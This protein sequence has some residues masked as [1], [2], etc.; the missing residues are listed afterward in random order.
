MKIDDIEC[1]P[2]EVAIYAAAQGVHAGPFGNHPDNAKRSRFYQDESGRVG[3][4]TKARWAKEAA[5]N[6]V[7]WYREAAAPE[8]ECVS[9]GDS[10]VDI[11]ADGSSR[12][13]HC[14]GAK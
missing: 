14:R 9:C 10:G 5:E 4:L 2:V 11:M 7:R 6:A 1:T 13:C 8:I 12:P 3:A